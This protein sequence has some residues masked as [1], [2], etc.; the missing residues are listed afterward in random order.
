MGCCCHNHNHDHHDRSRKISLAEFNSMTPPAIDDPN[1]G[2]GKQDPV[3]ELR[4]IFAGSPR[5]LEMLNEVL[6]RSR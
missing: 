4:R 2:M 5:L 3:D 1:V 6:E